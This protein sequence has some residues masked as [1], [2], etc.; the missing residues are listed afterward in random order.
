MCSED[1]RA[2]PSLEIAVNTSDQM[3]MDRSM[4]IL[5]T[6]FACSLMFVPDLTFPAVTIS[7]LHIG[8][9]W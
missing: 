4:N 5:S 8:M 1:L 3:E 2:G 7:K 6:D 9:I